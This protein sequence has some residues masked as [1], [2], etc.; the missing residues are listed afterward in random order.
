MKNDVFVLVEHR[1][2]EI[3]DITFELLSRATA[4]ANAHDARVTALLLT[5]KAE[6]LTAQLTPFAHRIICVEDEKLGTFNAE[7]Y[8]GV[9]SKLIS[10]STPLLTLIGHSSYGWELAPALATAIDMPLVMGC[11][12]VRGDNSSMTVTKPVYGGKLLSE[13]LMES[14][15]GYM[16]TFP[17]GSFA[18]EKG[19]LKAEIEQVSVPLAEESADKKFTRFVE[20]AAGEVDITQA[21][22]IVTIGRGIKEQENI[23]LIEDFA[24]S[25]N[26]VVACSR[27]IVDA[28]WLPKDRQ[29]GSSGKTVKPKLYIALGVSGDFQ[30]V[31]GMKGS[32]TIIAVN[33]DANAPIFTVADYGIVEDLFKVVPALKAKILEKQ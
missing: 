32:D 6:Q 23:A 8:L 18:V 11:A 1:H 12:D 13:L 16:L 33:K 30:H 27:P 20:A 7:L 22:K 10:E 29:V 14:S 2:N 5:D 9:L 28:G 24:E 19:G 25:I 31:L 15:K 4:F 26:A 17:A 3:R 21:Q